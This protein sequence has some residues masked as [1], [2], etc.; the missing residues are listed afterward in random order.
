MQMVLK[1]DSLFLV[2][3]ENVSQHKQHIYANNYVDEIH[4]NNVKEIFPI[5]QE[6]RDLQ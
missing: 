6:I 3:D 1:M 5:I 4:K 2:I